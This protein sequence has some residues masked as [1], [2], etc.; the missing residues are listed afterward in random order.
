MEKKFNFAGLVDNV[1]LLLKRYWREILLEA[2]IILCIYATLSYLNVSIVKVID[3]SL[4]VILLALPVTIYNW[5]SGKREKFFSDN[6]DLL[7]NINKDEFENDELI[8]LRLTQINYIYENKIKSAEER[9]LQDTII[10]TVSRLVLNGIS[11]VD[12]TTRE[13]ADKIR[14]RLGIED[15]DESKTKGTQGSPGIKNN[16]GNHINNESKYKV[17]NELFL[18]AKN[19]LI[20]KSTDANNALSVY[21]K[22]EFNFPEDLGDAAKKGERICLLEHSLLCIDHEKAL[23]GLSLISLYDSKIKFKTP[24]EKKDKDKLKTEEHFMEMIRKLDSSKSFE[25][26]DFKELIDNEKVESADLEAK[27]KWTNENVKVDKR[28]AFKDELPSKYKNSFIKFSRSYAKESEP[29]VRAGWFSINESTYNMIYKGK[30]Y[31]NFIFVINSNPDID[32]Q[33]DGVYF[34][35]DRNTMKKYFDKKEGDTFAVNKDK[36]GKKIYQFYLNYEKDS[37]LLLDNRVKSG[38]P[39]KIKV[40]KLTE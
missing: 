23:D 8:D 35:F 21:L 31:S 2:F 36:D 27:Y 1:N 20:I 3:G 18:D 33:N 4:I 14:K 7:V 6:I 5:I 15:R 17:V 16:N 11:T 26:E 34:H 13:D 10:N 38:E 28:K 12:E 29:N 37:E 9:K 19:P 22:H 25:G 30:K 24:L 39:V 32:D 40:T